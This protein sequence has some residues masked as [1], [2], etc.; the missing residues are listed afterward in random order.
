[1]RGVKRCR[2]STG[3]MKKHRYSSEFKWVRLA[4][5]PGI[6]TREVAAAL[7]IHPFMLSRW[8]REYR[9][10]KLKGAA[11]PNLKEIQGMEATVSEHLRQPPG[12]EGPARGR[13]SF[14][15]IAGLSMGRTATV[16]SSGSGGRSPGQAVVTKYAILALAGRAAQFE[17]AR[18]RRL[19]ERRTGYEWSCPSRMK[20]EVL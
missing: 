19:P 10:G 2:E 14:T 3:R 11:H 1:M 9:E 4:S 12:C 7:N 17:A 8:K 5:H 13:S 20:G 18:R 16:R 6:Q 15:P